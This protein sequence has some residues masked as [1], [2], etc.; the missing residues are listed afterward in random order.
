M[1]DPPNRTHGILPVVRQLNNVRR[2]IGNRASNCFWLMK[3]APP[4]GVWFCSA[5]MP[6]SRASALAGGI[7]LEKSFSSL[8]THR[9]PYANH[10][11]RG[12]ITYT[13]QLRVLSSPRPTARD[14]GVS[15]V[16]LLTALAVLI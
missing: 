5:R 1:R 9:R 8:F 7:T 10:G 12:C 2:L 6:A 4:A 14:H 15:A 11:K 3:P 13:F 16:R